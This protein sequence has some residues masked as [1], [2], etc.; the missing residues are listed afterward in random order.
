MSASIAA[1]GPD[2]LKSGTAMRLRLAAASLGP[3]V[4]LPQQQED[5]DP[6]EQAGDDP[7]GPAGARAERGDVERRE[8]DSDE[9]AGPKAQEVSPWAFVLVLVYSHSI[10]P[11]GL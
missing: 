10:V 1:R 9:H 4:H 2:V 7:S 8:D 5:D 11:G 6:A 3:V